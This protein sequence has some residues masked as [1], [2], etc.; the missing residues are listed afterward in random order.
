ML[1]IGV[2]CL[3]ALGNSR[4]LRPHCKVAEQTLRPSASNRKCRSYRALLRTQ[5]RR[6]RVVAFAP[7]FDT[8]LLTNYF[9][10]TRAGG[11][12]DSCPCTL[13]KHW[14]AKVTK[15]LTSTC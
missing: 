1:A 10:K 3:H 6:L 2:C 5:R 4:R 13:A 14:S 15:S 11:E 9:K 8:L 7:P 12:T